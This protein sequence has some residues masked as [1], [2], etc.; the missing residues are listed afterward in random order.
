MLKMCLKSP[1]GLSFASPEKADLKMEDSNEMFS[2]V[3]NLVTAK[4]DQLAVW[5]F[6]SLKKALD[7]TNSEKLIEIA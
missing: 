1:K 4:P 3:Y 2:L 6:H 5:N 7:P